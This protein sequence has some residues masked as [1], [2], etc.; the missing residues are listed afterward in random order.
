MQT[1]S[2]TVRLNDYF[3]TFKRPSAHAKFS[4][5]SAE[6]WLKTGCSFSVEF[7][8]KMQPEQEESEYSIEG[9]LAHS[10][11]EAL[12]RKEFYMMQ[13]PFDLIMSLAQTQDMGAEMERCANEY[14]D[15][16]SSYLDNHEVIGDVVFMG[17]ERAIPVFPE[18]FCFGTADFVIVGTKAAVLVDFKY[19]RG[20]NV[21][22]TTPQLK[23]YAAGLARF[24]EG[25]GPDYPVHIVIHQ[26]RVSD[27]VK[28]HVYS[29]AELREFLGV[30]WESILI[31][32]QQGLQPV[33]GNHCFWCPV[34]RT[35]DPSKKC[36]LILDKPVKLAN[37]AFDKFFADMAGPTDTL[38][39]QNTA[40]RD[41]AILKLHA[42]YPLIK[43][44]VERTTEEL[45][46]RIKSGEVIPGFTVRDHFGNR[47]IV[48][49]KPEDKAALIQSKWPDVDPWK[50]VPA[51]KKIKT[52]TELEKEIGKT[53]IN[54]IC[55]KKVTKKLEVL[56]DKAQ[57]V[58][59]ELTVFAQ[60]LN[61]GQEE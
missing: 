43:E 30:I 22:A 3:K 19:G 29:I 24:L 6:R 13:V 40:T 7:I 59:G 52:L 8:E 4:P 36:P 58:L 21:P 44:T 26:P 55:V 25:V 2:T 15:I 32:E 56:D 18:K 31:S 61:N 48:G 10:Y 28:T 45:E 60:M 20:K 47:E 49:E 51:T 54:T 11:C 46:W 38:V 5:S 1:L 23:V 12:F 33:E 39:P 37:E 34:R 14:V 16:I 53:N 41:A 9:T 42:L 17:P 57:K 50:E 35:K 27:M